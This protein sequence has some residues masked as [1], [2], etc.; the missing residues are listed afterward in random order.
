MWLV[1][2]EHRPQLFPFQDAF[3]FPVFKF[4]LYSGIDA[5][6][7]VEGLVAEFARSL[8]PYMRPESILG[9]EIPAAAGAEATARM[10]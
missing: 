1:R 4:L 10:I 5:V 2:E 3:T 9:A 6:L 8:P 7:G